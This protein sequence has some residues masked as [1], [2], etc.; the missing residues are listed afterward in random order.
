M[1]NGVYA[2]TEEV[3]QKISRTL[4]GRNLSEEHKN[5]IG[6]ANKGRAPWNKFK[7]GVYSKKRLDQLREARIGNQYFLGHRHTEEAKEKIRKAMIGNC[8]HL[9]HA[10]TKVAKERIGMANRGN[11]NGNWRDNASSFPYAIDFDKGLK[12]RIRKR[13]NYTCRSCGV[14]E[15]ELKNRHFKKLVIHH[16]DYNKLNSKETNLIALCS[17][18]NIKVNVNRDFWMIYF[19]LVLLTNSNLGK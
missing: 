17:N 3:R 12:E 18:C 9:G 5:N 10:H 2:R 19:N 13:D 7:T 15:K 11:K 4:E 1:P 14:K 8:H 6:L 16:I